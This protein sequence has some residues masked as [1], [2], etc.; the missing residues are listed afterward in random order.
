MRRKAV[1]IILSMLLILGSACSKPGQVKTPK[2]DPALLGKKIGV[3]SL[4]KHPDFNTRDAA[5]ERILKGTASGAGQGAAIALAIT[6]DFLSHGTIPSSGNLKSDLIA[7]A[8]IVAALPASAL[9]G[10]IIG[11]TAGA[12]GAVFASNTELENR[13][14]DVSLDSLEVQ[15]ALKGKLISAAQKKANRELTDINKMTGLSG[16]AKKL[17][18]SEG[19][20]VKSDLFNQAGLDSVIVFEAARIKLTPLKD[21]KDPP[22]SLYITADARVFSSN[23]NLIYTSKFRCKRETHRFKNWT[24]NNC[25]LFYKALDNCYDDIANQAADGIFRP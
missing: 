23:G 5:H 10:G 14:L 20:L 8:I 9:A 22:L 6:G 3:I 25:S 12:I 15:T 11:G 18:E 21:V 7:L 17:P 4:R 2:M 16:E 19:E 13:I 24:E 1:V